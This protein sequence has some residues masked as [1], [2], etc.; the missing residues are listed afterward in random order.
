MFPTFIISFLI[1]EI[2]KMEGIHIEAFIKT[3]HILY[4]PII[5]CYYSWQ[6]RSIIYSIFMPS[7]SIILITTS[8]DNKFELSARFYQVILALRKFIFAILIVYG[9]NKDQVLVYSL[10]SLVQIVW[11]IY[12]T[13]YSP[14]KYRFANIVN[15]INE[16][17]LAVLFLW[18]LFKEVG[19]VQRNSYYVYFQI[20]LR[21]PLGTIFIT[22][23]FIIYNLQRG[24]I[25]KTRIRIFPYKFQLG[26]KRLVVDDQF[27]KFQEHKEDNSENKGQHKPNSK[28]K[29]EQLTITKTPSIN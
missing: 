8:I 13:K 16:T 26:L 18:T 25:R 10:L 14:L 5:V 28:P 27:G 9:R 7:Q 4:F 15:W 24:C 1:F 23:Y 17:T 6:V 11:L 21:F 3:A 20:M 2:G 12:L 22:L 19:F 29:N